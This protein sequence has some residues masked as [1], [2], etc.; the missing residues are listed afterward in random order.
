MPSLPGHAAAR[1]I[2]SDVCPPWT[3]HRFLLGKGV[4]YGVHPHQQ[5]VGYV[6]TLVYLKC[7]VSQGAHLAS[8]EAGLG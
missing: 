7:F 6:A 3:P 1:I 4:L 5:Q 2:V 8:L